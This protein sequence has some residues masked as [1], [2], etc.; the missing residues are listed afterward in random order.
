MGLGLSWIQSRR[1]ARLN[2]ARRLLAKH[3]RPQQQRQQSFPTPVNEVA[4]VNE[5][6]SQSQEVRFCSNTTVTRGVVFE[7]TS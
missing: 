1:P 4:D 3:S 5:G 2:R 6:E 7:I